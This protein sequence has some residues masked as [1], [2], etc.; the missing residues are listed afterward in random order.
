M[1]LNMLDDRS[2]SLLLTLV[3]Q[4]IG[5]GQPIASKALIEHAGLAL[6]SATVR[7]VMADLEQLGLIASPHTS[8]GRVPTPRGY[9]FFVDTMM[10]VGSF[11]AIESTQLSLQLL[12]DSPQRMVHNAASL[13]SEISQFAGVISTPKRRDAQQFFRQIEFLPLS[14]QRIL[15]IIITPEGDVQN[16]LLM[17][18]EAYSPS[19]L[20]EAANYLNQHCAGLSIV[21]IQTQ[22]KHELSHLQQRVAVLMQAAVSQSDVGMNSL[23]DALVVKGERHLLSVSELTSDM[24]RLRQTFHMFDEKTRLLQLLERASTADGVQIFIGGE[25]DVLPFDGVSLISAPYSANNEVIGTLGVIGPSRMAYD[26]MIPLVNITAQLLS[27]AMSAPNPD[28][29]HA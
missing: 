6:S 8:A 14:A 13:L 21:Q 26:K 7:H 4:Y 2:K 9:R 1:G 22:I 17:V 15:V 12:P 23:D 28:G 24:N 18:N 25:S 20:T 19:Q 11:E 5:Q 3:A 27:R 10:A 16:R 29:T